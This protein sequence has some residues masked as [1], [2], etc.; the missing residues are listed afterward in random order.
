MAAILKSKMAAKKR[1]FQ[2]CKL[3]TTILETQETLWYRL[4]ASTQNV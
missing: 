3:P 1:K 2:P 4:P